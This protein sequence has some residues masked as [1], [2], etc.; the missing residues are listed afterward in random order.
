MQYCCIGISSELNVKVVEKCKI[1]GW[2]ESK[3]RYSHDSALLEAVDDAALAKWMLQCSGARAS[4]ADQRKSSTR[5]TIGG[6]IVMPLTGAR[7]LFDVN[8]ACNP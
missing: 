7:L 5:R 4:R 6:K 1:L 2:Q 3:Q 8:V